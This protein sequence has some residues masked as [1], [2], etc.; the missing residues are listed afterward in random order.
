MLFKGN[1]RKNLDVL[2]GQYADDSLWAAL[3]A[4]SMA[5]TVAAMPGGLDAD[6]LEG[7]ANFS[8]GQRQLLT[9]ARALL[10]HSK[11][12]LID[13]AS[14]SVDVEADAALQRAIRTQFADSTVLTIAHR[15]HTILDS[16]RVMVLR[17]G[18]VAE[19]ASPAALL[20]DPASEFGKLVR[21]SQ[22]GAEGGDDVGRT[23]PPT[24]AALPSSSKTS[25]HAKGGS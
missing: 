12:T 16:D 5:D 17:D 18:R 23:P 22:R 7:G 4:V 20:A 10:R 15:V 2:G 21:E 14:S 13:E 11:V 8:A 19:F 25:T 3:R 9:V 24:A 6:V 1:L